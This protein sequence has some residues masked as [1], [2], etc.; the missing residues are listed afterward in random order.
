MTLDQPEKVSWIAAVPIASWSSSVLLRQRIS[1]NREIR[2]P[3][4][5]IHFDNFIHKLI[6]ISHFIQRAGKQ[7]ALQLGSH[8]VWPIDAD[9]TSVKGYPGILPFRPGVLGRTAKVDAIPCD[10]RPI[11]LEDEGVQLPVLPSRFAQPY[12]V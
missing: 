1:M 3:G 11:S 5:H 12:N 4:L 2:V 7:L 6:R 9:Q 8:S 10:E